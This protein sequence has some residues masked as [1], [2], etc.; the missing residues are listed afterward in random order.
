VTRRERGGPNR[1]NPHS[2][3]SGHERAGTG[4]I[5]ILLQKHHV[6]RRQAL[7]LDNTRGEWPGFGNPRLAT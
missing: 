7:P 5:Q 1:D 2:R 4:A 3:T 6:Y